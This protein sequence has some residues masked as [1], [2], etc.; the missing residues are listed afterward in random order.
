MTFLK[1]Q[2]KVT[3]AYQ[4]VLTVPQQHFHDL[5]GQFEKELEEKLDNY[6]NYV[7]IQN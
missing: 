7:I 2:K 1:T 6:D 5:E 3:T 4:Y